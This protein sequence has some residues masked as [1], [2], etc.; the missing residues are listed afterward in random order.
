MFAIFPVVITVNNLAR[1]MFN[2]KLYDQAFILA[3]ILCRELC[4]NTSYSLSADRVRLFCRYLYRLHYS[5]RRN[6]YLF[7]QKP[8]I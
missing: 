6:I 7:M 2:Q 8:T 3:E 4:K 1:W 5:D